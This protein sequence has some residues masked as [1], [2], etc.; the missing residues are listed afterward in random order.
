MGPLCP[1]KNT[2]M[3]TSRLSTIKSRVFRY[4]HIAF[5]RLSP[6][7]SSTTTTPYSRE[8]QADEATSSQFDPRSIILKTEWIT[9]LRAICWLNRSESEKKVSHVNFAV[10]LTVA[11]RCIILI[12]VSTI[13]LSIR[14]STSLASSIEP[15][16]PQCPYSC[17]LRLQVYRK[18]ALSSIRR[19]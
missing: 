14:I 6:S 11:L 4:R 10:T 9:L 8:P 3:H 19:S 12:S 5:S 16:A 18:H 7:Q 2:S 17:Y 15:S 1:K 13:S